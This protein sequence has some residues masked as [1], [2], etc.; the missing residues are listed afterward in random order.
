MSDRLHHA[1][2]AA[3]YDDVIAPIFLFGRICSSRLLLG[4]CLRVRG[5]GARVEDFV[6]DDIAVPFPV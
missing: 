4:S 3:S 1:I 6:F 2:A 5:R